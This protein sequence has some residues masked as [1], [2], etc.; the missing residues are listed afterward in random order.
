[1]GAQ[2]HVKT[3]P[4][5]VTNMGYLT[6]EVRWTQAGEQGQVIRSGSCMEACPFLKDPTGHQAG[7]RSSVEWKN[8]LPGWGCPATALLIPAGFTTELTLSGTGNVEL[9]SQVSG[10]H[11]CRHNPKPTPL[12]QPNLAFRGNVSMLPLKSAPE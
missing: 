3:E 8:V 1:M 6:L 9:S 12:L 11:L 7:P 10:R 5:M 2:R 4:Y